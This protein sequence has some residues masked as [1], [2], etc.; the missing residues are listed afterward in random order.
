MLEIEFP[1]DIAYQAQGGPSWF[2]TVNQGFSGFEQTNQNWALPL[3]KWKIALDHKAFSYF[4]QVRAMWFKAAGR[5]QIFRFYDILDCQATNEPCAL[6]QDSPYTGRIY[7]LQN[8][9]SG[10]LSTPKPIFKP[11]TSAVQ[12][13]DGTYCANTVSVAI[14][15]V[16]QSSGWTIDCTTGLLTF[17]SPPGSAAVTW[18]GQ[19]HYPVRFDMDDCQAVIEPSDVAGG[20]GLVSWPDVTLIERR[21]QLST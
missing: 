12:K 5:A 18:S 16:A 10:A 13:F 4:C 14:A 19:Y 20:N 2:T 3:G 9:Y 21:L 17:S 8:S 6:V 1:R 11:I 15:G 7:Q